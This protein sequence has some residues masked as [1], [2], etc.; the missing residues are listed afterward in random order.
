LNIK[1]NFIRDPESQLKSQ[2]IS[3][4]LYNYHLDFHR[5][6]DGDSGG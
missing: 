6:F 5:N 3:E 4:T 1:S 2:F